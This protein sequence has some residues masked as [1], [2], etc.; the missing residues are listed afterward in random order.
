MNMHAR[1]VRDV[2]TLAL[3]AIIMLPLSVT[4]AA[5]EKTAAPVADIA[6]VPVKGGCFKM[7]S[8]DD[9]TL[10]EVCVSD[11]FIGKYEVTQGQWKAVMG[12]NPSRYSSCGNDCPVDQVSWDDIQGFLKKLN[13]K[14]S[15]QYRLP[16]E[17]EWEYAARSGGKN[18]IY[19]GGNNVNPVAWYAKNSAKTPHKVG[20][21]QANGLGIYDMS[22]NVWEWVSDCFVCDY[23]KNSP[24]KDPQGPKCNEKRVLRGGSWFNTAKNAQVTFRLRDSPDFS[25]HFS[26]GFRLASSAT[27]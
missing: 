26:F 1:T 15:V 18:E 7:G 22:G 20:T 8:A 24:V 9:K 19:S 6:L 5:T 3:A 16:T 11:F 2:C 25:Y 27:K 4:Y 10:H 14:S 21:K 17:A 23:Y 12:T 13:A